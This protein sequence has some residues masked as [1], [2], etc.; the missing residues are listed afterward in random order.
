MIFDTHAHL[1]SEQFE[2]DFDVIIQNI[3][4]K[5]ISLIVNPGC[6]IHTSKKSVELSEKYDFIPVSASIAYC[7]ILIAQ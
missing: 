5:K 6:D 4:N 7:F 3:I 2:V 1:D